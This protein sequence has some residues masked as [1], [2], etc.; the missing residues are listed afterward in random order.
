MNS[1]RTLFLLLAFCAAPLFAA[2][3]DDFP[4]VR[5]LMT[6]EQFKAAGLDKLT[7]EQIE[8]LDDWLI[9]YTVGEAETVRATSEEVKEVAE[10]FEVTASIKPPFKGWTGDTVFYLD[11]GQIWKQRVDGRYQYS[12]DDTRVSITKGFFGNYNMKLLSAGKS[13]GV[14]RVK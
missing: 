11:N 9:R 10:E 4:G 14:K 1:F 7:P 2:E 13:I 12:G 5:S 8:A 6:P 3:T